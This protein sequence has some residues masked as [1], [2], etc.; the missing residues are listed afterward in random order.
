MRRRTLGEPSQCQ[1]ERPASVPMGVRAGDD[2]TI[3]G[4]SE[5]RVGAG[6]PPREHLANHSALAVRGVE[7]AVRAEARRVR[8]DQVGSAEEIPAGDDDTTVSQC[9]DL[10][11]LA[12]RRARQIEHEGA[13]SP[14]RSVTRA[15][16][17]EP[18][19]ERC[20][21]QHDLS[22]RLH[23]HVTRP[24]D[25]VHHHAR[26]PASPAPA[27][28]RPPRSRGA[29]CDNGSEPRRTISACQTS[30]LPAPRQADGGSARPPGG[31]GAAA[32][33]ATCPRAGPRRP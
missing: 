2:P 23:R 26:D 15:R 33:S 3:A 14:K 5:L 20:P 7:R 16:G 28:R 22:T 29:S 32:P 30:G 13:A 27:T 12:D 4:H 11:D 9:F 18:Q 21:H 17:R 1:I 10:P 8:E 31:C 24:A 19:D 6:A 25:A